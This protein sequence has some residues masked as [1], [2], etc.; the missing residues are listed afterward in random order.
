VALLSVTTDEVLPA[1][2]IDRILILRTA[3]LP[4]VQ[5]ARDEL[6]RRYPNATVGVLG[7]RLEALGAFG[8]CVQFEVAADWLTPRSVE[9]LHD[10]IR[11]F[12]P[13]LLVMCL[14]ND[15]RVGYERTSRVVRSLPARHKVVAAYDRRWYRWV[16]ADFVEGHP[17][18]RWLVDACGIA[19]LYPL[20][21]AYLLAK[22]ARPTYR[23]TPT[24]KPVGQGR[25]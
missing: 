9:P 13:D 24:N 2:E 15:W 7:T 25:A 20:V 19:L 21:A 8:D 23:A 5:R 6:S 1:G 14:N 22:P 3:Q 17:A 16:H 18:L 4:E 10:R 11:A 12:A